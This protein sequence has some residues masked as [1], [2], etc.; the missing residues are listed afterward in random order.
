MR[1]DVLLYVIV[2]RELIMIMTSFSWITSKRNSN[3]IT[4]KPEC[5][6]ILF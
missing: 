2:S 6:S 3:S 4:S 5:F 1:E